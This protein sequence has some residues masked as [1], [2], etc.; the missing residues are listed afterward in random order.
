M[1][2]NGSTILVNDVDASWARLM[3]GL[4]CPA[5]FVFN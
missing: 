2:L 5:G 3:G 1:A 4:I